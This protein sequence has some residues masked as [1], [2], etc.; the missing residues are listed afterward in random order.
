MR[1]T[2]LLPNAFV[3]VAAVALCSLSGCTNFVLKQ[4][5]ITHGESSMDLR[6]REVIENLAMIYANPYAIPSYV[7]IYSGTVDVNDS[8][9]FTSATAWARTAT[10]PAGY[11]TAFA[12][13]SMDVLGSRAVKDNWAMDPTIVP[14]K[15]RAMRAACRWVL[16]GPNCVGPD[17]ML[18]KSYEPPDWRNPANPGGDRPGYYFGVMDKLA[19]LPR[20]WL[21]LANRHGDVPK[22][23]CYSAGCGDKYVWVG[24][25]GMEGLSDFLLIMQGLARVDFGSLYYPRPYTRM[26]AY[27]TIPPA[28]APQSVPRLTVTAYVDA[29]GQ[30]TPND[31]VPAIPPKTRL[32][33]VGKYSDLISI[34]NASAKSP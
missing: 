2:D 16:F 20:D 5:T 10:K 11:M 27:D 13:Q 18:L 23:A 1:A 17:V 19:S 25:D 15:L 3:V 12:S 6:Y 34:I 32:D 22:R 8:L 26:I 4:S 29:D 24:P 7:S 33:N 21:H 28:T 9:K 31:G 14:E 30:L